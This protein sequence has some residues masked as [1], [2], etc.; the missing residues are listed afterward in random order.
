MAVHSLCSSMAVAKGIQ[1]DQIR[2]VGVYIDL[3]ETEF[4]DNFGPNLLQWFDH[5][6]VDLGL[7]LWGHNLRWTL[8]LHSGLNLEQPVCETLTSNIASIGSLR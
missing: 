2:S 3:R 7:K 4:S 8:E 5:E 6:M 1:I